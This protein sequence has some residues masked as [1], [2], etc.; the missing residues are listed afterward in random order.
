MRVLLKTL[1]DNS[2]IGLTRP[3]LERTDL[4]SSLRNVAYA[5]LLQ[6]IVRTLRSSQSQHCATAP[7]P[8]TV[9]LPFLLPFLCPFSLPPPSFFLIFTPSPF[10]SFLSSFL[11][12]FPS[13]FHKTSWGTLFRTLV[14]QSDLQ[15]KKEEGLPSKRSSLRKIIM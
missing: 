13:I 7:K 9:S 2:N 8:A 15:P 5:K 14:S 6:E 11:P 4:G 1:T 10:P 3:G 12:F